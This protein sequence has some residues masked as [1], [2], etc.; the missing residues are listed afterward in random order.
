MVCA[1]EQSRHV[2]V[3]VTVK[4]LVTRRAP[5]TFT[6]AAGALDMTLR[7]VLKSP[8]HFQGLVNDTMFS[9]VGQQDHT[10]RC[11]AST[12]V[13]GHGVSGSGFASLTQRTI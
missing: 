10:G 11:A 12:A 6:C 13:E 9:F 5:T 8:G 7:S 2:E 4:G 1:G 3:K